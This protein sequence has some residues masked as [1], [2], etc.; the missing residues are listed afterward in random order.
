MLAALGRDANRVHCRSTASHSRHRSS[1]AGSRTARHDAS[2]I[3]FCIGGPDGLASEI[4]R[5]AR[6][7]WS[8]SPLTLPHG[9]ARIVVVEALY[10]AVTVIKG[11]RIIGADPATPSRST[12]SRHA[13]VSSPVPGSRVRRTPTA[14]CRS[15]PPR[16]PT[17]Q[18][19]AADRIRRPWR[20][21][22]AGTAAVRLVA[23][24]FVLSF[25]AIAKG[26]KFAWSALECDVE[27]TLNRVEGKSYF[28]HFLVRARLTVPRARTA[29]GRRSCSRSPSRSA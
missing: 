17:L 13:P 16:V 27:G 15:P 6:L 21:L 24:C 28:T 3:A 7:R 25:R 8:V 5:R 23:D 4:D 2:E 12:D 29:S 14:T 26:S 22:V 10:R 18:T 9:L 1:R 19:A 11:T 20:S